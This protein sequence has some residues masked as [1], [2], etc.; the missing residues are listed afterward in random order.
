MKG[1]GTASANALWSQRALGLKG[2]RQVTQNEAAAAGREPLAVVQRY[3]MV[4]SFSR[5]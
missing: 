1:G 4:R 2:E 3:G 5:Q